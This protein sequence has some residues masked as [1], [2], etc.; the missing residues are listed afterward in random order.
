[1]KGKAITIAAASVTVAAAALPTGAGA[2]SSWLRNPGSKAAQS[3]V[4][5]PATKVA[6]APDGSAYVVYA[7]DPILS[8]I[9]A[10]GKRRIR[11]FRVLPNGRTSSV[12]AVSDT[13]GDAEEP[14]IA[15]RPDGSGAIVYVQKRAVDSK[16]SAYIRRFAAGGR[17]ESKATV[18]S[19]GAPTVAS[20]IDARQPQVAAG[21]DGTLTVVW[22]GP[23]TPSGEIVRMLP[24][25]SIKRVANLCTPPVGGSASCTDPQLVSTPS[26]LSVIT[27]VQS[28][29]VAPGG[30]GNQRTVMITVGRNDVAGTRANLSVDTYISTAPQI[31]VGADGASMIAWR[32]Q[33]DEL[34]CP[35][36]CGQSRIEA[37]RIDK[38]GT[39]STRKFA[40]ESSSTFASG[41]AG[42]RSVPT[43]ASDGKGGFAIGWAESPAD[44][45][46]AAIRF[47]R[48]NASG[49]LGTLGSLEVGADAASL[50]ATPRP[51]TFSTAFETGEQAVWVAK[52]GAGNLKLRTVRLA[53]TASPDRTAT[54]SGANN[55]ARPEP[56]SASGADGTVAVV[57][58]DH[59]LAGGQ[60][61]RIQMLNP[62]PKASSV[63]LIGRVKSGAKK[64]KLSF[65]ATKFGTAVVQIAPTSKRTKAPTRVTKVKVVKSGSNTV[66]FDTSG[67]KRGT[68]RVT[69]TMTDLA[70]L[71]H[72]AS[73]KLIVTR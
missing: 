24:D 44:A 64:A 51:L 57:W 27:W 6:V 54:L 53:R 22:D 19:Q 3:F 71:K 21:P 14:A 33:P 29:N 2:A 26:G 55:L 60:E 42:I 13:T 1:M 50:A 73:A 15:I 16:R 49:D 35:D 59:K 23:G 28:D 40:T 41:A 66:A 70:G 62:Q 5:G 17:L 39:K 37:V 72:T 67:I 8:A 61:F 46:T 9:D 63:K 52:D 7:D 31:A 56:I 32:A 36:P 45:S 38:V 48:F 18:L 12:A 10:S 34:V 11:M 68:Y 4:A 20:D 43:V 30:V 65:K 58:L 69:V 25:G 47:R